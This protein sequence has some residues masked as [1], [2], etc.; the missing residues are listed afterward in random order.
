[1]LKLT[2]IIEQIR[3]SLETELATALTLQN[4]LKGLSVVHVF[5]SIL[6]AIIGQNMYGSR[7]V[8]TL[9]G[10][11]TLTNYSITHKSFVSINLF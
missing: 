6:R 3:A 2:K 5:N 10:D 4:K 8:Y 1:M 11:Y 7:S 9:Q